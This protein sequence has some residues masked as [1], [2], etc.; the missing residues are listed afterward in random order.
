MSFLLLVPAVVSQAAVVGIVPPSLSGTW[1]HVAV[2]SAS[3]H[4]SL[5]ACS[6]LAAFSSDSPALGTMISP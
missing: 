2:L 4:G 1:Y 3:N 5:Q 6:G